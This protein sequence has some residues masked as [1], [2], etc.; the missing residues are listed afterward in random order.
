LE[1]GAVE[2]EDTGYDLRELCEQVT[3]SLRINAERKQLG[4]HLD[5]DAS[6]PRFLRGDPAR[7]QQVLV[8]LLGNAVK[9]TEAGEVR[10]QVGRRGERLCLAIL[11]TGIGIDPQRLER[12]FE[13]FAQADASMT[14]RFGGTGLG[15]TI[16]RQL[17]ELMG[18]HIEDESAP[19]RG[20][21]FRVLLPLRAGEAPADV[22]QDSLPALP[23]L[24]LLVVD[25]VAQNLELMQLVLGRMG[26]RVRT[27][28]NG[29]EALAVLAGARFDAVLMDMHMPVL[30]GLAATAALREREGAAGAARTPVLALTA[31]VL[32]EDRRAAR[33]AGMD[34][35]CVKPLEPHA[36]VRELVR[37]LG[38]RTHG[39]EIAVE[40]PAGSHHEVVDW[41]R[42][43]SLW[44][45]EAALNNEINVTPMID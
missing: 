4:L 16:A 41:V 42:G 13:P 5:W 1:R 40:T 27:A 15:T 30:D 22:A 11:D 9:F 20:S 39:A 14:R 38:L 26:H 45:G 12:I 8:N 28:R 10:L 32:E 19:G 35:F 29:E 34:G 21:C 6:V 7:L 33:A 18:G 25:D 31:S 17:V 3:A 43:V 36:L 44:G 37:V 23:A 24:D 2:I